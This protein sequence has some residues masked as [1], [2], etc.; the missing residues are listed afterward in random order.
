M[1]KYIVVIIQFI[2]STR[3]CDKCFYFYFKND[4]LESID[5]MSMT[6]TVLLLF[7]YF[8]HINLF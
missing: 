5:Y 2:I 3:I 7:L 8:I 4:A 6:V 1:L